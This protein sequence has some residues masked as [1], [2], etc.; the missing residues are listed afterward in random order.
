MKILINQIMI[1]GIQKI[2][3]ASFKRFLNMRIIPETE[4]QLRQNL[5][6]QIIYSLKTVL[7]LF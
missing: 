6:M 2:S 1:R 3:K 4:I 7:W 5:M